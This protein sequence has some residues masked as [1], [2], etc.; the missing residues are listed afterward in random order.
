MPCVPRRSLWNEDVVTR[1]IHGG[2]REVSRVD[3]SAGKPTKITI[4]IHNNG[5]LPGSSFLILTPPAYYSSTRLTRMVH[6]KPL[7]GCCNTATEAGNLL[8]I[9]EGAMRAAIVPAESRK[10]SGWVAITA[11]ADLDAIGL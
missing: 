2:W 4:P 11:Y 1:R 10:G 9:G 8:P 5:A 3:P 6:G 7:P